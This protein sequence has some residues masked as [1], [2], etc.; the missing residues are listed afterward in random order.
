MRRI[1]KASHSYLFDLWV[2][3]IVCSRFV[4]RGA[5][6]R[7]LR[8]TGLGVA[9]CAVNSGCFF[10]SRRIAI[11]TGSFLNHDVFL[12]GAAQI[13]I[14]ERCDLGPRVMLITSTHDEGTDGR[15]AGPAIGRPITIGDGC[16]IGAGATI[17]PG[18]RIGA[19][20]FI[21]AG[22]VVTRDCIDGGTYRGVPARLVT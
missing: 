10:G 20:V 14:G 9:R 15:R 18:V 3:G 21:A 16:W 7:L 17:L 13:Q 19:G 1:L 2:N 8:A 6:W 12:D 4:P 22:A 11:G 5:R